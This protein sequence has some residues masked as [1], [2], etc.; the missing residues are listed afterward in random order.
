MTNDKIKEIALASGFKLKEQPDNSVDLNPYVYEFALRLLNKQNVMLF[1]DMKVKKFW[2]DGYGHK[3]GKQGIDYCL[4]VI[5]ENNEAICAELDKK[6]EVT[7][8]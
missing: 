7:D 2:F 4:D 1:N 8:E 5:Q 6:I 3:Q